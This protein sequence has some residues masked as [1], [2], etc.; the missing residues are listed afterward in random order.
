MIAKSSLGVHQQSASTDTSGVCR[1]NRYLPPS[2]SHDSSRPFD[3][4]VFSEPTLK[5]TSFI[6]LRIKIQSFFVY[7]EEKVQSWSPVET[8]FDPV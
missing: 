1:H 5:P 4:S 6:C 2:L 3:L 7:C 8:G